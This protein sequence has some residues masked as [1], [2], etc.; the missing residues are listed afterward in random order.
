MVLPRYL[1]YFTSWSSAVST[2]RGTNLPAA[3]SLPPLPCPFLLCLLLP[4]DAYLFPRG[5]CRRR[6]ATPLS[7]PVSTARSSLSTGCELLTSGLGG[8]D[9]AIMVCNH[10]HAS[11]QPVSGSQPAGSPHVLGLHPAFTQQTAVS[12]A[13]LLMQ[14]RHIECV[15]LRSPRQLADRRLC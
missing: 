2:G 12:T 9:Y 1:H 4:P 7:Y 11:S 14:I 15:L 6:M 3:S 8:F 13:H 5:V 10:F